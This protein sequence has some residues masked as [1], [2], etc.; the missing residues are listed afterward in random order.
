MFYY[1]TSQVTSFVASSFFGLPG[2]YLGH[3]GYA[4]DFIFYNVRSR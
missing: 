4:T 1:V 2:G 3:V